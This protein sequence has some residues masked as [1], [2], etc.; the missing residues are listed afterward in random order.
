MKVREVRKAGRA[1]ASAAS[2]SAEAPDARENIIEAATAEIAEKGLEGA[3][4]DEI[5]ERTHTSKRMIYYY[6]GSKVGLYTAVLE[7]CY[8]GIREVESVPDLETMDPVSALRT[9]VE[10]NFDHH[11][12]NPDF[13][14]IVMSENIAKGVHIAELESVRTR[15]QSVVVMLGALLERGVKAK[16]FRSDIDPVSLH[17]SISALCFYNVSNR[18]TFSQIFQRD[19]VSPSAV[20]RRRA[21]VVDMILRWCAR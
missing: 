6:F 16:V 12:Q 15:N 9:V 7:R 5:A 1:K 17:M 8:A 4:I 21:T 18:Y 19:M 20:A 3:R 10:V 13:V 14:R 2:R 11:I